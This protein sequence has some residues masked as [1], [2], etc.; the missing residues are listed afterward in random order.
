MVALWRLYQ[1][2]MGVGYLP[3]AGGSMDQPVMMIQAFQMM[4]DFEHRLKNGTDGGP[5]LPL[6]DDDE[7]DFEEGARRVRAAL[8]V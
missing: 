1:G 5:A 7:I 8:R 3:D 6:N 4:S 2:G